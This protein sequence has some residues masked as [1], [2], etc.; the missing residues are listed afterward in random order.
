MVTIEDD[1]AVCIERL[2]GERQSTFDQVLNEILGLGL[3]AWENSRDN[4][5]SEKL[6]T[7][8]RALGGRLVQ[9]HPCTADALAASEGDDYR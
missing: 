2:C 4:S 9:P 7:T 3:D 1:L 6:W 5:E 8:P